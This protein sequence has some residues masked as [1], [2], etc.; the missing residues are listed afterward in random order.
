MNKLKIWYI[1]LVV[2]IASLLLLPLAIIG[3]IRNKP[4]TLPSSL[5]ENK[6]VTKLIDFIG[7]NLEDEIL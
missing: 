4:I 6:K 5:G 1:H 2:I 7:D 3:Y